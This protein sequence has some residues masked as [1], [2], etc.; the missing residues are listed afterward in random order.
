M[1][2]IE[3]L[4][5]FV[6]NEIVQ[7]AKRNYQNETI[8]KVDY[9]GKIAPH[10]E[11]LEETVL[12][13]I[14]ICEDAISDVMNLLKKDVFFVPKNQDV[15]EAMECVAKSNIPIT[16]ISVIQKLQ[17]QEKL[18]AIGGA[19][20]ITDLTMRVASSANVEYNAKLLV[21]K[22]IQRELIRVSALIAD[23]AFDPSCQIN[24]LTDMAEREVLTVTDQS[25]Q[26]RSIVSVKDAAGEVF[27][28]ILEARGHS[29]DITGVPSGYTELDRLTAGWQ[30]GSMIVLAARPGMGKTAFVISMIQNMVKL[31]DENHPNGFAVGM[32]SLE[33]SCEQ[34]AMRLLVGEAELSQTKLQTGNVNDT[35]LE[36][37]AAAKERISS[38]PIYFDDTPG[39][40]IYDFRSKCRRMKERYNV[41]CIIVDY[42][43]LMSG[44]NTFSR[45]QEISAISRQIKSV[46]M[47]LKVPVIA[48]SQL[49]RSVEGRDDK[50]PRLSDLRESG[51]IEQDADMV[52]FI[53]RESKAIHKDQDKDGKDIT[54]DAKLIIAKNRHGSSK[55]VDLIFEGK[56][57]KFM[58]K[59]S[60]GVVDN[61]EE[62]SGTQEV[63]QSSLNTGADDVPMF[64]GGDGLYSNQID[65]SKPF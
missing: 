34:L 49:N 3:L 43:Q 22:Y 21:Q 9:G 18:E 61:R 19:S 42:L 2:E 63:I 14:M 52:M 13:Q 53:H 29:K 6:I 28:H 39:L 10:S 7:M 30:P 16:L 65:N 4:C 32:F 47:E 64:G 15:F 11:Q 46:A 45:E 33:M 35:E 5:I 62:L 40:N 20:Y 59:L 24:E 27:K 44:G 58:D 55:D 12:G 8:V 51:A 17:E 57:M 56:Y 48:L 25:L 26:K 1:T 31:S 36:R 38:A 54:K 41:D 50:I 37:L 23:K 60:S